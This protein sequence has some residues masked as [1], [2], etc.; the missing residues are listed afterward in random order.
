M[1]SPVS[2]TEGIREPSQQRGK[3][4]LDK[5][6]TAGAELLAERG[7]EGFTLT[8]VSRRAGV[9]NGA[10]YW[11][12]ENKDALLHAIH[13]HFQAQV[14]AH[15]ESLRDPSRWA[16]RP[17]AEVVDGAVREVAGVFSYDPQLMRALSLRAGADPAILERAATS[18]HTG[19]QAFCAL[20]EPR[21]EAAGHEDPHMIADVIFTAISGAMASRITWPEFHDGPD[22][23]WDRFVDSLCQM[24]VAQVEAGLPKG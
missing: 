13:D 16:G 23:S 17:L 20:L 5:L 11:R 12:I 6:L 9:S 1:A 19:S 8:E 15:N 18:I 3:D 2:P 22:L 24:A 10:M 21:L 7:Y 4:A 14:V